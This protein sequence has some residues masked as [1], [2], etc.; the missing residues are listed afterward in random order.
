[1]VATARAG[2]SR[3]ELRAELGAPMMGY[4]AREGTSTGRHDPLFVRAI[5]LEGS[6]RVL[7]VEL[8]LCL[9]AVSQAA[10]LRGRIAERTGVDPSEVLVGCIHTH[11]GPE[12]GL[13]P[14]L[15]GRGT[16]PE[17]ERLFDC[18]VEAAVCAFE[19]AE[20]ARLG[21]G[22]APVAIGR[23]RRVEAG[24]LDPHAVVVR[25][26][27]RDGS[28]LAVLYVHGCHPTALGHDN[29]LFSADWPGAAADVIESELPGA[30]WG[31]VNTT[32]VCYRNY[33]RSHGY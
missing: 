33:R 1:M 20:P 30:V 5:Y 3:L 21:V 15:L 22:I 13:L 9:I 26:D 12:T 10:D 6:G 16:P 4:G 23:N 8:D 11:S 28:P 7:L 27:R 32:T 14:V 17:V 29:L 25:V 19:S 31:V 24:S 2:V 18:V